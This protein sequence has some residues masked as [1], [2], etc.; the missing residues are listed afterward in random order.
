M[1]Q[2]PKPDDGWID[3]EP[4]MLVNLSKAHCNRRTTIRSATMVVGTMLVMIGIAIFSFLP[5][6]TLRP[7]LPNLE[8]ERIGQL[9]VEN[10]GKTLAPEVAE[11]VESH[12]A[13]CEYCRN[14][15]ERMSKQAG[16]S[17]HQVKRPGENPRLFA[18]SP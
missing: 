9:L 3:C 8:C 15:W 12:L 16:L 10:M 1:S 4:G 18:L 7:T 13:T 6:T 11:R 5:V 14:K 2:M 17:A